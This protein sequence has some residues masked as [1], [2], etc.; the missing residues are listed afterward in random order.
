[1]ENFKKQKKDNPAGRQHAEELRLPAE[2]SLFPGPA[3]GSQHRASQP[4]RAL[5]SPPGAGG[6]VPVPCACVGWTGLQLSTTSKQGPVLLFVSTIGGNLT[7]LSAFPRRT[8]QTPSE[9]FPWGNE[10]QKYFYKTHRDF[11][12]SNPLATSRGVPDFNG[13]NGRVAENYGLLRLDNF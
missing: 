11:I 9:T 4:R 2:R 7:F 1:M 10:G 5:S 3:L 12:C 13:E 6:R 8:S